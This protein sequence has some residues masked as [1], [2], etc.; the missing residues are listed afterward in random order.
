MLAVLAFTL[1][2]L[3]GDPAFTEGRALYD[4]LEY[5]QAVFR[6]QEVALRPELAPEDKATALV[7]LGL[8][9]A[10]TGDMEA[11][12]RSFVDAATLQSELALPVEVAPALQQLFDD[13]RAEAQAR[14][15]KAPPLPPPGPGPAPVPVADEA[16]P[17]LPLVGVALGAATLAGGVGLAGLSWATFEG[18]KDKQLYQADAK[19]QLDT[20][21]LELGVA[22]ALVPAGTAVAAASVWFLLAGA[23]P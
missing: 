8:S 20:A 3:A 13:A 23:E 19:G 15:E 2:S 18:A 9:F 10:G 21:N 17:V 11:A 1:G 7:W 14:R 4:Q 22:W 5:E 6:F 16:V 12:R